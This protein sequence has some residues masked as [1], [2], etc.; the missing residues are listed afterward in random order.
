MFDLFAALDAT[1]EQLDFP[2]L[3]GSGKHGWMAESPDGPQDQGMAPLFDMVLRHVPEP[4]IEEGSF[5]L[6]GTLLEANPYLGRLITGRVFAGS[7]KP[8]QPSRVL[9]R[10]VQ[11]SRNRAAFP[12]FLPSAALSASD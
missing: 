1:D 9:D 8:N 4:K 7:I 5:R 10:T 6:L 12:R 11:G 3:Y 2:I